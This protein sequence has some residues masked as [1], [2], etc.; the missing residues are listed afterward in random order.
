MFKGA[1][2]VGDLCTG[3]VSGDGFC[4]PRPAVSGST[5]VLINGLGV[6]REG[7]AWGEH[8]DHTSYQLTASTSVF[9]NG[10]RV[11]REGD[12]IACGSLCNESSTD[13][14]IGD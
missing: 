1:V 5:D 12:Q 13:V 9:I 4:P 2:R 8:C 6:V 7:D 10:L 3:H 14:F 11:A